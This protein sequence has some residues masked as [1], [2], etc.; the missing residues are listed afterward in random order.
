MALQWIPT[1]LH[2]EEVLVLVFVWP[3]QSAKWPTKV[4]TSSYGPVC[5]TNC[6]VVCYLWYQKS[7]QLH[8]R[9]DSPIRSSCTPS[10]ETGFLRLIFW[11]HLP[12]ARSLMQLNPI[13]HYFLF[14][15]LCGLKSQE[16]LHQRK[17]RRPL[18]HL[19]HH[20]QSRRSRVLPFRYSFFFYFP[21]SSLFTFLWASMCRRPC[22]PRKSTVGTL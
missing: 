1:F 22:T 19:R 18:R 11:S 21:F 7:P 17:K 20:R 6:S 2:N 5:N 14:A 12:A 13:E 10:W 15:G 9:S 4:S 8:I 3:I 16:I